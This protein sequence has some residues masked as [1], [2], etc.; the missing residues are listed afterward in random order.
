[1][2]LCSWFS[3]TKL[4]VLWFRLRKFSW[5]RLTKWLYL[6]FEFLLLCWVWVA[7]LDFCN[8]YYC[9]M[10]KYVFGFVIWMFEELVRT[11]LYLFIRSFIFL[12]DDV[13]I[14][15]VFRRSLLVSLAGWFIYPLWCW[16]F[17]RL[18]ISSLWK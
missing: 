2:W 11:F 14:M 12:V 17:S 8:L 15:S 5:F 1:V 18:R 13:V 7:L 9:Y 4:I 3:L 10:M 16:A 6:D